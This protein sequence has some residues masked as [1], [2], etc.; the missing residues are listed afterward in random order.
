MASEET[1]GTE[2]LE[3]VIYKQFKQSLSKKEIAEIDKAGKNI[4]RLNKL[5]P[6]VGIA[7]I[8]VGVLGMG[9]SW[10][11]GTMGGYLDSRGY[12]LPN[13]PAYISNLFDY[14]LLSS[15][16]GVLGSGIVEILNIPNAMKVKNY[17]KRADQFEENYKRQIG[18]QSLQFIL[19]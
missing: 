12:A 9:A 7:G 2:S 16:C 6:V 4:A 13:A 11:A 17:L 5:F 15:I 10:I 19:Q 14:G 3:E 18:E 1:K 8:G